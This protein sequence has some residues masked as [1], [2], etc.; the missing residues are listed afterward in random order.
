LVG[1]DGSAVGLPGEACV[2]D[3]SRLCCTMDVHGQKIMATGVLVEAP[4]YARSPLSFEVPYD[5]CAL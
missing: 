3:E 1:E 5:L 4:E 2:G